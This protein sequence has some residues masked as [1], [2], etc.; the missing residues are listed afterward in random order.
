VADLQDVEPVGLGANIRD[1]QGRRRPRDRRSRTA[2]LAANGGAQL[3]AD[4]D[5][6]V[7]GI[8]ATGGLS[9]CG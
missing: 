4:A 8:A 5:A 6:T 1:A 2:L 3:A 9:R 7:S